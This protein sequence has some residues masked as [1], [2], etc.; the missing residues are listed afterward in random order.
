[1]LKRSLEAL[2]KEAKKAL[3]LGIGGGG[4][5]LGA[6]PTGRYLETL[7]VNVVLGSVGWERIVY[8]PKP[9]PRSLDEI[10]DF[11]RLSETT[12]LANENTRTNYGV[13][14]QCSNM[15][16][17]LGKKTVIVDIS[18]GVR[19]VIEGLNET[20]KR[21]NID[22]IVGVDVG[23]DVLAQGD[24]PG[25]RSPLS[26][27]TMLASLHMVNVPTVTAVFAPSCDGELT[28]EEILK[29]LTAIAGKG[30]YLGARG[31]TPEDASVMCSALRFVKTEASLLPLLA[32]MG[33]EGTVKIR[34]GE[35]RV[36]LSILSTLTFYLD[37]KIVFSLS[38][39]AKMIVDTESL[40]EINEC[41]HKLNIKTEY[42]YELEH[43]EK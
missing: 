22:L 13:F 31:L 42:D 24:E 11:E 1:M 21:L 17:F 12:G 3:V 15:A 5:I 41:F 6:L 19:G 25:L 2:A 39:L 30:G 35:R 10:V 20:A 27:V 16:R 23:G 36:N 9:G 37:T 7:G 28:I 43:A 14:F 4:D 29:R 38:P 34:R 33:V 18:K 40:E 8:D 26:D 32:W